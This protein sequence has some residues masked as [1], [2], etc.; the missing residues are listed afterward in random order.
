MSVRA[1]LVELTQNGRLRNTNTAA[2]SYSENHL[3]L[4]IP[5]LP[6][7]PQSF[8][9]SNDFFYSRVQ[10]VTEMRQGDVCGCYLRYGA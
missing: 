10:A 2:A 7:S 1:C 3:L 5:Q 4:N 9:N 6:R 8:D